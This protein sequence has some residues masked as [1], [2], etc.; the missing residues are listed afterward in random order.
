[1]GLCVCC[2]A[3]SVLELRR[4]ASLRIFCEAL[5]LLVV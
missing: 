2:G 4:L 5:E 3:G 1:V